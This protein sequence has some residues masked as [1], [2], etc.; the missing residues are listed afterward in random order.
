MSQSRA[1]FAIIGATLPARLVAGLLASAHGKTVVFVG[2]SQAAYRLPRSLDLS[3][4]PLTRPESWALLQTALPELKALLKK[5]GAKKTWTRLDPVFFASEPAGCELLAHL[6]HMALGFGMEAERVP[7]KAL[8]RDREGIVLPDAMLLQR[9]L[10]EPVLDRWLDGLGVR[11]LETAR[12]TLSNDGSAEITGGDETIAA[13]QTVLADD[14]A[15][16]THL[17][18]ETWPALFTRQAGASLLTEPT[19]PLHAPVMLD[20][21]TNITL[22]QQAGRGLIAIGPGPLDPFAASVRLLL[23]KQR[24]LAQG[25]QTNFSRVVTLDGAPAVG[26]INGTGPDV[27]AGFGATGAFFAPAIARWLS[28]AATPAE[29]AWLAARLVDRA[30]PST[31]ADWSAP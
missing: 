26:R 29:N 1:D 11:R 23:G 9:T 21:D 28:G 5:L 22:L 30:L 15:I 8:G 31:V 14:D 24:K 3:V 4:A 19:A 25:G 2:P 12:V 17:V 16:L 7:S 20:L 18:P 27:L 10:L 6:R 13:A